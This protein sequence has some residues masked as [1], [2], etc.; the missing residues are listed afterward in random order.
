MAAVFELAGVVASAAELIASY[1]SAW[2]P[3]TFTDLDVP[4]L[5][6]HLRGHAIKVGV[7]S[8]TMWPREWHEDVFRPDGVLDLIDGAVYSSEIDW[9]TPS[10]ARAPGYRSCSRNSLGLVDG[11]YICDHLVQALYFRLQPFQPPSGLNT[12]RKR[13]ILSGRVLAE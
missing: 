5:L 8:N 4:E 1:L 10:P 7:L 3:Y 13:P 6:R 11:G 9:T 2:E 12:Q